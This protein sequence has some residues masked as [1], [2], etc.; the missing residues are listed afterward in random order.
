MMGRDFSGRVAVVTGGAMGIGGAIV[1]G[2]AAEGAK[3]VIA[4]V[5]DKAAE[6]LAQRLQASGVEAL[7][8][9]T[10]VLEPDHIRALIPRVVEHYGRLD[11]MINNAGGGIVRWDGISM[12]LDDWNK[13]INL[14]L[15]APWLAMVCAIEYMT[16]H[17]GGAIVNI[18][19]M[20][21]FRH[22]PH[23]NPAYAAAKSGL[24]RLTEIAAVRYAQQGIR[25][26]AVAPG[27]TLT[28]AALGALSEEQRQT[29][30]KAE[31]A[32]PRLGSPKDQAAAVL[33]LCS[34]EAAYV[35]GHTICVD[36]GWN[37][38]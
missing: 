13:I 16:A 15:T 11:Y 32:L 29:A 17:G 19:S 34:D 38:K 25:V 24:I 18:S 26:N 22:T 12:A 4:D 9:R 36:G 8:V 20:G 27:L 21:A 2:F 7:Y 14:N 28:P 3:I 33:Y 35:T 31:S 6:E 37:V 30:I 10:D 5:N 1:Q 23:H